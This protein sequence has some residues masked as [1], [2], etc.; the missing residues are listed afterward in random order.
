[1]HRLGVREQRNRNRIKELCS[2]SGRM[3]SGAG[4]VRGLH[5]IVEFGLADYM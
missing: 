2:S 5:V 4:C 3:G 1:M